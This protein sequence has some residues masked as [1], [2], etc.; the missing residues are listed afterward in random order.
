MRSFTA[1]LAVTAIR[2]VLVAAAPVSNG[3]HQPPHTCRQTAVAV[4][5]AGVAGIAAAQT[6][7]NNSI[8]DFVIIDRND[9]IGGRLSHATFGKDA[10][11]KPYTVELGANW[12]QGLGTPDGPENPIWRLAK[13]WGLKNHYSN[14]SSIL[15]YDETGP[16]DFTPLLDEYE[17]AYDDAAAAAG[18]LLLDDLQ[19]TTVRAGLSQ[20]GWRPGLD[21]KKQAV[22]YWEWDWETA[23]PPESSSFL[24]GIAG[25]NATFNQWSDENNFSID[26]RGYNYWLAMEASEFLS[27]NDSRLM[28][29]KHVTDVDYDDHGVI[30]RLESGECIQAQHAISTFSLG[31]LQHDA[32]N[33]TPSF[34]D[35]KRTAIDEF[36][37]GIYTKIFY[38]FNETFWDPDTQY[39][40]YADPIKRGYYPI[41]QSLSTD[42]FMPGSNIIF[43]TV[44]GDESKRL[45]RQ[46]PEVTKEEGLGVL[47]KMFPGQDIP[48][49]LEFMYPTWEKTK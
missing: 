33:F 7:H 3:H 43:A 42:G 6:L 17:T 19:D 5:G 18:E 28:L 10:N 16:N 25:S 21:M 15:T 12:I 46:D 49:P 24:F 8:D 1:A 45:E 40:L 22:E 2:I 13:K 9:Y 30:V 35:W 36:E 27:S 32:V 31:V 41:W 47:R 4:L 20:A 44:T 39:F 34:P 11:G 26:Q 48:E 38:Q 29:S 14:Y 37:M 23:F